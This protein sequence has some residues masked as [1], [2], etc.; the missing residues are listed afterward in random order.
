[1]RSA[2]AESRFRYAS[3][4]VFPWLYAPGNGGYSAIHHSPDSSKTTPLERGRG[5]IALTGLHDTNLRERCARDPPRK[6]GLWQARAR[7]RC[8]HSS[9]RSRFW[10]SR[11]SPIADGDARRQGRR[12]LRSSIGTTLLGLRSRRPRS[13]AA[14]SISA[15]A[16]RFSVTAATKAAA[17]W[18]VF[19]GFVR[20]FSLRSIPVSSTLF[21][22]KRTIFRSSVGV[23]LDRLRG[24]TSAPLTVSYK[25][26]RFPSAPP[27]LNAER[28]SP[29]SGHRRDARAPFRRPDVR[30]R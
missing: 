15:I 3:A 6:R 25:T 24:L 22:K 29:R 9:L 23:V 1:M 13:T 4:F 20:F 12:R 10:R 14:A 7:A 18:L 16:R 27:C 21:A 5:Q 28:S 17:N 8:K 30:G 11:Q 19:Q 26:E 2:I